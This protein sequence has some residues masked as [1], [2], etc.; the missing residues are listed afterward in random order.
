MLVLSQLIFNRLSIWNNAIM[1]RYDKS[2]DHNRL[3]ENISSLP[4]VGNKQDL[5]TTS[6][7]LAAFIK[8]QKMRSALPTRIAAQSK[9]LLGEVLGDLEPIPGHKDTY[10]ITRDMLEGIIARSAITASSQTAND[11]GRSL[12]EAEAV[13]RIFDDQLSFGDEPTPGADAAA[14]DLPPAI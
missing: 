7:A 13:H 1:H 2:P 3:Y 12:V 14:L 6:A 10:A 8:I 11:V 5:L 9:R 4:H